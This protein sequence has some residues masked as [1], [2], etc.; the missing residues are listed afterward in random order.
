VIGHVAILA[1]FAVPVSM[2][3]AM[4]KYRLY[5]IDQIISRTLPTRSSPAC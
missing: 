5:D 4:L 1:I 2:G 3:V